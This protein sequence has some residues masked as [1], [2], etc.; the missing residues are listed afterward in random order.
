MKKLAKYE[1]N[2]TISQEKIHWIGSKMTSG[3]VE[4]NGEF[5]QIRLKI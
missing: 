1:A 4:L 2:F 5:N 3:D